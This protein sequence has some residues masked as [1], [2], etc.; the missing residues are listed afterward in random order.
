[1]TGTQAW[2][3]QVGRDGHFVID[4][5]ISKMHRL[6]SMDL[7]TCCH[8]KTSAISRQEVEK[9]IAFDDIESLV[10]ACH[11]GLGLVA[12][13]NTNDM[14]LRIMDHQRKTHFLSEWHI[15]CQW[16][17]SLPPR[18]GFDHGRNGKI[19][20]ANLIFGKY[21]SRCFI[22]LRIVHDFNGENE[23]IRA[24]F[25]NE[26]VELNKSECDDLALA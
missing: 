20:A 13:V 4:S 26:I 15:V 12:R 24:N 8:P 17:R 25:S 19:I 5:N 21:P 9:S 14:Q 1:V 11:M 10:Y 16:I 6:K 2:W 3:I 18:Q 7:E 22:I 23:I